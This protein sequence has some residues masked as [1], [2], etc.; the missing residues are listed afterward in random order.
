M[1]FFTIDAENNITVHET[2]KKA[3]ESGAPVF[4]TEV[5][6]ADLIGVDNKRLIEIWNSLPGVKPVTKFTNR[7][8]ATERIWKAIQSLGEPVVPEA[9]SHAQSDQQSEAQTAGE[10]VAEADATAPPPATQ[11]PNVAPA[12]GKLGKKA[13]RAKQPPTANKSA[14]PSKKDLILALL[15][16]PNGTTLAALMEATGWQAH[17]VRGFI[18]GSLNKKGIPVA[19]EK[20]DGIRIYSTK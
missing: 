18:S 19:S 3:K 7:K 20:R 11:T 4:N 2:R 8:V 16:Q 10:L 6:F 1:K 14:A 15:G 13:A 5:Q 12:K 17:S 9:S